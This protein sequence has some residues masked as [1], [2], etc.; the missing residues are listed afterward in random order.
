[1]EQ[2]ADVTTSQ[3]QCL[4]PDGVATTVCM[5][6]PWG[7]GIKVQIHAGRIARITG[8]K[9]H[10]FSSGLICPKALAAPDVM[11]S[12][13]RITSPMR[14][15]A[16]GWQ[17]IGWDQAYEILV[18]N[19]S[20]IKEAYGAKALAVAIGMPVLLGGNSTVSFLRRFCDIY[21]TPNCFSVE[22]I[23]FRCQII[24]RILTLGTYEVPDVTNTAC[25]LVWGNNPEASAPPS[26]KRIRE[27]LDKGAKLI[28]IDPRVTEL[29]ARADVHLQPR[30]GTDAALALGMMQVM[31]A[32][33][34][35]DREFVEQW[36]VGMDE[37]AR[38][39]AEYPLE[40]VSNITG[41]PG[42]AV[43]QA[44][45]LFAQAPS[46]CIVQGTN[47]LDQHAVGLQNS[48]SVAILQAITGNIDREGGFVSTSKVALSPIRLP[49]LM[50]GEPLGA[51]RY[52]L[53]NEV[54]GRNFGEGQAM[55]LA[56]AILEDDPY[57]IR[58]LVVAASN[59][60]LTWPNGRKLARAME[61]LDFLAVMDLFLTP[62]AEKA[63]LFLP[64]ATFLERVELCDYYGTLQA[65]PY[66]AVRKKLFQ[67]G[68]AIS[69]LEFWIELGKRMGY[70]DLFPWANSTAALDFA[71]EPSGF[72]LGEVAER[73]DGGMPF[74]KVRL[75]QYL[76]KAGFAT[77]SRKIEL[78]SQTLADLGHDPVPRHRESPEKVGEVGSDFPL[79][80]TT[81]ARLLHYLHSEYR[82]I[83]RLAKRGGQPEAEIHPE[84]A[85]EYGIEHGLPLAIESPQGSITMQARVTE[86]ILPGVIAVPHGWE[87]A[88]VNDITDDFCADPVIGYPVLKSKVCRVRPGGAPA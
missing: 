15:T 14:R 3:V 75:E 88:S 1:M 69:D 7:C 57:P 19:L 56:D 63:N 10:P 74:G 76:K 24:A 50:E 28:V 60:L 70:G 83:D 85:R 77:P 54:W 37:L 40:L 86:T 67:V 16:G 58:G 52:P 71:V 42:D 12:P 23:C 29:A 61:K 6:C 39:A 82:D 55:L 51:D 64:A 84:T 72:N 65:V 49:E 80:L 25:V 21:G 8:N 9:E 47:A 43:A 31:I 30:P 48:R 33:G 81:G 17:T 78:F 46:A 41:V 38:V 59:P 2:R 34:L 20:R 27:A 79:I 73:P 44:A 45:R 13:R 5:Q 62:T 35:Y 36:T 18:E 32:E 22:S 11:L 53:F 26:A 66:V 87:Q 68:E 4:V